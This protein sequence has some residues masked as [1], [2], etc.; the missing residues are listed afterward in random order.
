VTGS[1][2]TAVTWETESP[3]VATVSG[4]GIVVAVAPGA[5]KIRA[6]S[7][8][9]P[10]RFGVAELTVIPGTV[11]S[12]EITPTQ[13]KLV[14]R[15][16]TAFAAVARNYSGAVVPD[17]P[18]TWTSDNQAVLTI[19]SGG[20]ATGMAYGTAIVRAS[21]DGIEASA[22]VEVIIGPA[23][24]IEVSQI[25]GVV[26]RGH[27]LQ[28]E[29]TVYDEMDNVIE[30]AAVD[31]STSNAGVATVSQAG[32]VTGMSGGVATITARSGELQQQVPVTV[33]VPKLATLQ[34]TPRPA[35][36]EVG[37][38]V[39]LGIIVLDEDGNPISAPVVWES[40][41]TQLATVSAA[42]LLTGI[43]AGPAG[44]EIVATATL[45]G[46]TAT[47]T[48]LVQI[49]LPA[50]E[51]ISLTC[52]QGTIEVGESTTCEAVLR[53]ARGNI[54]TGRSVTWSTD[55]PGTA[56]V[57]A[58]GLVTGTG[59]GMTAVRASSGSA[60]AS[61]LIVV[62][63]AAV[64]SVLVSPNAVTKA[65]GQTQ[66][67]SATVRDR[68]GA[69]LAGRAVLWSS[70][71][72][73]IAA[74]NF[75]GNVTAVSPGTTTI[76][77]QSEGIT[78]TAQITVVDPRIVR[79]DNVSLPSGTNVVL[80]GGARFS[81]SLTNLTTSTLSDISIVTTVVQ[82]SARR[83]GGTASVL[84][85]QGPGVL[86][87]GG[88]R[89]PE[90]HVTASNQ[91]AGTGTLG[92]GP[93]TL[94]VSVVRNTTEMLDTRHVSVILVASATKRLTLQG[95]YPEGEGIPYSVSGQ[96][97]GGVV[98]G[99]FSIRLSAAYP[100]IADDA[101]PLTC[102][103]NVGGV[104][105]AGMYPSV[106]FGPRYAAYIMVKDP[107]GPTPTVSVVAAGGS[108]PEQVAQSYCDDAVLSMFVATTPANRFQPGVTLIQ[109]P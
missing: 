13:L 96:E 32:A 15:A 65:A 92:P 99:S 3:N 106:S 75:S 6:R 16:T 27:S 79:I 47:D 34:I 18:V 66:Q 86:P 7:V 31:W 56:A 37:S 97:S 59:E 33:T 30:D 105:V 107:Y 23:A 44:V 55:L 53:D 62:T 39:Q 72:P 101:G 8:A 81:V 68:R 63:R 100:W 5:T 90:V 20:V 50:V 21:I 10:S 28:L 64:G 45:N 17:R 14:R 70:I 80:G 52:A 43:A 84:C 98:Q 73:M 109:Y 94:V 2:S 102:L 4:D 93:A 11:L 41:N 76:R 40:L 89:S 108:S 82:G 35:T 95:V 69:V 67:F 87:P 38:T 57:T 54:L 103:K 1:A 88:C 60:N 77:A 25:V 22:P 58:L 42:G 85:N 24:R 19:T 78:G 61:T 46:T 71:T 49:V 12:I 51:S 104:V 48:L 29:A 91:S 74:V 26:M 9:D 36:L 83:D